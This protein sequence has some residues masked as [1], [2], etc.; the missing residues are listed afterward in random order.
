MILNVAYQKISGNF[1]K[2]N[3]GILREFCVLNWVVVTLSAVRFPFLLLFPLFFRAV[4]L[5]NL[6]QKT[7][8]K[9]SCDMR[10][11]LRR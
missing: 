7:Y 6:Q 8:M 2:I 3:A 5:Q 10:L 11:Q 4:G 9:T 1:V